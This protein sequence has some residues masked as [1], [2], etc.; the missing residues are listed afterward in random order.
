M[1]KVDLINLL[2]KL[3]NIE[4][5]KWNYD[6]ILALDEEFLTKISRI[7]YSDSRY[8][9]IT[10]IFNLY[11]RGIFSIE[12]LKD[13]L[14]VFL[15]YPNNPELT[16]LVISEIFYEYYKDSGKSDL[17]QR[18]INKDD[19][20]VK[21]GIFKE[22]LD[23]L[24]SSPNLDRFNLFEP[25]HVLKCEEAAK[26]GIAIEGAKLLINAENRNAVSGAYFALISEEAIN[27]GIALDAAKIILTTNNDSI[28]NAARQL[29]YPDSI[30][31]KP[32]AILAGIA[33]EGARLVINSPSGK[34]ANAKIN[35]L[36]NE[37]AINA[38]IAIEGAK[39]LDQATNKENGYYAS[40]ALINKYLIAKNI[41]MEGAKLI[42][43]HPLDE[44]AVYKE[45]GQGHI[46]KILTNPYLLS[47]NKSLEYARIFN[48]LQALDRRDIV[49]KILTNA[50]LDKLGLAKEGAKIASNAKIGAGATA[51]G[52]ILNSCLVLNQTVEPTLDP[53]TCL[54]VIKIISEETNPELI[55]CMLDILNCQEVVKNCNTIEYIK[56]LQT[57]PNYRI[58][59]NLL[60]SK[61]NLE[62]NYVDDVMETI[63]SLK[64]EEQSF[65]YVVA[66][67]LDVGEE[68]R[69][70]AQ[71]RKDYILNAGNIFNIDLG[72]NLITSKRYI[73]EKTN[74]E[75]YD[76][77]TQ[78]EERTVANGLYIILVCTSFPTT[79]DALITAKDLLDKN[80]TKNILFISALICNNILIEN[81]LCLPLI[82]LFAKIK[83]AGWG[84][85]AEII[86]KLKGYQKAIYD[87]F[88][89]IGYYN[90]GL[91]Q[92]LGALYYTIFGESIRFRNQFR[93][94][95]S[96]SEAGV[97]IN[98]I[99]EMPGDD[100]NPK[101]V[102]SRKRKL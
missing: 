54:Q 45:Y 62:E 47:V 32:N 29:F 41:A 71:E 2:N 35:V 81:G 55:E 5:K 102:I 76:F 61:N 28:A 90:M 100:I 44:S 82:S 7:K 86:K 9:L 46:Y 97:L 31:S 89:D 21:Y 4:G 53:A 84:E 68:E 19:V 99:S 27:A 75:A 83:Y 13:I 42:I 80:D 58:L 10:T 57:T 77:I 96:L 6:N 66:N 91:Q 59:C 24:L 67:I 52:R 18:L 78:I 93:L 37:D 12:E 43:S 48:E 79:K 36:N 65:K 20:L 40:C 22:A 70:E 50:T 60:T 64:E 30:N 33:L 11:D 14:D 25:V 69:K 101:D 34:I 38:N 3:D 1:K 8:S 23:L 98:K 73:R 94:K 87:A 39:L 74:Y 92:E 85:E 72:Y 26:A 15:K 16:S 56:K 51:I 17:K 63:A 49:E 95:E 88:M